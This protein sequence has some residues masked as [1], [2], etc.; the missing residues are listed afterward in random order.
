MTSGKTNGES[1]PQ[2]EGVPKKMKALQY[3]PF[4]TNE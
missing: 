2:Y 1:K 4:T 3:E